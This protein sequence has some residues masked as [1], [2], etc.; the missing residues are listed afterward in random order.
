MSTLILC[1][2]TEEETESFLKA[3]RTLLTKMSKNKGWGPEHR[4]HTLR[5]KE[6]PDPEDG[7]KIRSLSLEMLSAFGLQT[8]EFETEFLTQNKF[9]FLAIYSPADES[10]EAATPVDIVTKPEQPPAPE[11]TK[12]Q[13]SIPIKALKV[14]G[15]TAAC[16]VMIIGLYYLSAWVVT[17]QVKSKYTDKE[18]PSA[19]KWG[20]A[21]DKLYPRALVPF[22]EPAHSR[23][24]ECQV[25]LDALAFQEQQVWDQAYA[26]YQDYSATYPDGPFMPEVREGTAQTLLGWAQAQYESAQYDESVKHLLVLLNDYD[27]TALVAEAEALLPKVYLAYGQSLRAEEEYEQAVDVFQTLRNWETQHNPENVKPVRLELAETYLGWAKS[28]YVEKRFSLA[29]EKLAESIDADPDPTRVQGPGAQ[30]AKLEA[31]YQ[32]AWGDSLANGGKYSEAIN[33]YEQA[34]QLASVQEVADIKTARFDAM[35]KWISAL[36]KS[37]NFY[38]AL[39]KVESAEEMAESEASQQGVEEARAATYSAFS[40]SSGKEATAV[41]ADR[42]FVLCNQSKPE[43]ELLPI[44]AL[45]ADKKGV[46]AVYSLKADGQGKPISTSFTPQTPGELYFVACVTTTSRI[47]QT[48]P[49]TGGYSIQRR[50]YY[51]NIKLYD[52]VT[53]RLKTSKEIAGSNPQTCTFTEWFTRGVFTKTYDGGS[54]QASD[55]EAW[56]KSY[57]R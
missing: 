20:E 15:I 43:T 27:E 31:G 18:C 51:W 38:T 49:Y 24:V 22:V 37:E 4:T 9:T 16:I 14:F 35:L 50:R 3:E 32:K 30:A 55:L 19:L 28:L 7:E 52:A 13:F 29:V 25:Y 39:E 10:I 57:I 36:S 44:L 23:T 41:I 45:D 2:L 6:F 46:Y 53:G 8:Q 56:F 40:Q 12:R 47:V 54:P 42:A 5:L 34:L 11:R 26:G 33:H 48:C 21:A 17:E 1:G